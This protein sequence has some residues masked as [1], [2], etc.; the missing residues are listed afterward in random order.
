M[1]N[2]RSFILAALMLGAAIW[3]TPVSADDAADPFARDIK[4]L[5][6]WFEGEFDNSEQLWFENDR[7][8]NTPE[9]EK[10]IRIHTNHS[11]LD[12]P[13]M[14]DHVFYVEE[15]KDNDPEEIFRQ[16]IV[17]FSSDIEENAIRMKQGF[18]KNTSKVKGGKNLNNLRSRD[19]SFLKECD[20]FWRRDAGQFKGSMKPKACVFGDDD[21]R[22]YSVHDLTLSAYKYWRVDTTFL[23]SDD[24]LHAGEPVDR[25][26]KMRKAKRYTCEVSFRPTDQ[27]LSFQ[28]LGEQTQREKGL[29]IHSQGGE[30]EVT[31][32]SDGTVFNYLMREKEYPYY[33]ERPEFIYFSIREKEATRST[34]YTVSD[35]DARRLGGQTAGIGFHCH[36]D[37]YEFQE[38]RIQLDNP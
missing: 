14:G 22:R 35:I 6:G 7:R 11:R 10:H 24:S 15:Y 3:A 8:S 34:L 9:D 29:S 2:I 25:P 23:T 30:F 4:I 32:K 16:R 21:K 37:G 13:D 26:F 18:F 5:T 19:V 17:I 12:L 31:R 1:M 36:R 38:S 27:S 20:V 28:E 33:A